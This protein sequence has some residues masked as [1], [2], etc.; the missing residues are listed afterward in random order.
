MAS[1]M[2]FEVSSKS[3]VLGRFANPPIEG[4]M[5][6]YDDEYA[7]RFIDLLL[8]TSGSTEV[9]PAEYTDN[10]HVEVDTQIGGMMMTVLGHQM[11]AEM[12]EV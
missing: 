7:A 6:S 1:T 3:D 11:N 5:R 12:R 8:Y 10:S 2:S 9:V 4:P